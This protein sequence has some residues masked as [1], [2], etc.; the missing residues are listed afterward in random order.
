MVA[1]HRLDVVGGAETY[2]R[3]VLP[4]LAATGWEVGVLAERGEPPGGILAGVPDAPVWLAARRSQRDLLGELDRWRPNVAY[5]HGLSDASLDAALARRFPTV[6]FAHNYHGTCVSGTKCH[7]RPGFEPCRR[8]LGLGCL[9]AY[10]PRGCGGRDPLTMIGL[11]RAQRRRRRTLDD[12]Q[13]VLVASRHMA[14]EYRRHGVAEERLRLVPLFAPDVTPDP[15]PPAA[16]SRTG[17]VLFV[18]RITP[19]KGLRQLVAALPAASARLNRKLTLIVAG[20]GPDQAAAE[21]DARQL[22]VSAEFLGWVGS[23][24]RTAEMR[25]ADVLAVPSVWP[26]PFGLVGIEAG[27]VGLPA[28]A[29]AAGGIG[30]WLTPGVSGEAAPGDRP[31][32]AALADALVRALADDAHWQRLRRGAWETS[33]RFTPERHLELLEGVLASACRAVPTPDGASAS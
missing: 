2:L 27:C 1:T 15:D 10:F 19:L 31:E 5:T 33:R 4:R 11:Y 9:T 23:E 18:G 3:A 25:A 8:T 12:Y 21:A 26:E 24:R 20:D 14:D 30:D 6:L 32:P 22:G 16:R 13:S 7:S 29:F 28:V 17:R